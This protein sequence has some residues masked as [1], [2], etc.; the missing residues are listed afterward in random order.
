MFLGAVKGRAED[1]VAASLRPLAT[2]EEWF[3][4]HYPKLKCQAGYKLIS[5]SA[6]SA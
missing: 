1:S 6:E 4:C 3:L 2:E 5:L